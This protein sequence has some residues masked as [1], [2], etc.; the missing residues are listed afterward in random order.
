MIPSPWDV[1]GVKFRRRF[2]TR[3]AAACRASP[4][5]VALRL[6]RQ[7]DIPADAIILNDGNLGTALD[8]FLTALTS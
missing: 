6:E 3:A 5:G 8:Q 4:H 1:K 2:R 7:K